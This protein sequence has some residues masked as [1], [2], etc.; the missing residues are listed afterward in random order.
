VGNV[1]YGY[2]VAIKVKFFAYIRIGRGYRVF[3]K[4]IGWKGIVSIFLLYP[5]IS[6]GSYPRK[7]ALGKNALDIY[8][9]SC[10][11]CS[12]SHYSLPESFSPAL[13]RYLL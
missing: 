9:F 1:T 3:V 7:K 4:K 8:N 5:W 12:F 11:V 2:A 10:S 6:R 13:V